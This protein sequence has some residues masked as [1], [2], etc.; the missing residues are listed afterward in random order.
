MLRGERI[1]SSA[2]SRKLM[3]FGHKIAALLVGSR[4]NPLSSKRHARRATGWT[5]ERSR[6]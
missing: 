3:W 4:S 6:D 2:E 1:M 5:I